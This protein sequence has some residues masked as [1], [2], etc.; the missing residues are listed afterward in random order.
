MN[1]NP[2]DRWGD[3]PTGAMRQSLSKI[4]G[5]MQMNDAT[6][7]KLYLKSDKVEN[8]E[9][10]W[11]F[12][13]ARVITRL[14]TQTKVAS[15]AARPFNNSRPSGSCVLTIGLNESVFMSLSFEAQVQLVVVCLMKIIFGR[16]TGLGS[17][18]EKQYGVVI[19]EISMLLYIHKSVK[20]DALIAAGINM[21]TP[22]A[23]GLPDDLG[24]VAYAKALKDLTQ[25]LPTEPPL[26]S[27]VEEEQYTVDK[28]VQSL[29][30]EMEQRGGSAARGLMPGDAMDYFKTIFAPAQVDWREALHF[31]ESGIGRNFSRSTKKRAPRRGLI[32]HYDGVKWIGQCNVVVIEDVSGSRGKRQLAMLRTELRAIVNR[33]SRV[34][35]VQ[36]DA[37]YQDSREFFGDEEEIE[38]FGRGGTTLQPAIDDIDKIIEKHD[39]DG[40]DMVIMATDG[41]CDELNFRDHPTVIL[42]DSDGVSVTDF[43]KQVAGTDVTIAVMQIVDAENDPNTPASGN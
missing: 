29:I 40:V 36:H 22:K 35:V 24:W 43:E 41:A 10:M 16:L 38:V 5:K 3:M 21:P 25:K 11:A 9:A 19:A 20:Y 31:R 1:N 37:A 34:F 32:G 15:I 6:F 28:A 2:S 23:Y 39:I 26:D 4:A 33:G 12:I 13:L 7:R 17:D 42:L 27:F 14:D 18:L 8:A 30:D